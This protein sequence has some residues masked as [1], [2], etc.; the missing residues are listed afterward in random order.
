MIQLHENHTTRGRTPWERKGCIGIRFDDEIPTIVDVKGFANTPA[1][2]EVQQIAY[3]L[4][5]RL[6]D[7]EE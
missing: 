4:F 1:K 7:C 5:V 6:Q 2:G 3:E